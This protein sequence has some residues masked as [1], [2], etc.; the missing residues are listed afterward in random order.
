MQST[1]IER[2]TIDCEQCQGS[3]WIGSPEHTCSACRGFGYTEEVRGIRVYWG[4]RMLGLPLGIPKAIHDLTTLIEAGC[5]IFCA[6]LLLI[7]S[8]NLFD[9]LRAHDSLSFDANLFFDVFFAG[10]A[11]FPLWLGIMLFL[12]L[13]F[14]RF[15][16]KK[17][18]PIDPANPR[19]RAVLVD[20][21]DYRTVK[22]ARSLD[23]SRSA[24]FNTLQVLQASLDLA[25]RSNQEPHPLHLLVSLMG[26]KDIQEIFLR[27][28]ITPK[29]FLEDIYADTKG[30]T[31]GT[32]TPALNHVYKKFLL[33]SFWQAVRL[34][35]KSIEPQHLLFCIISQDSF[36]HVLNKYGVQ[37]EDFYNILLWIK[38]RKLD[39]HNFLGKDSYRRVPHHFMNRS[40]SAV[41]TRV[42]DQFSIDLT[43]YAREGLLLPLVNREKEIDMTVRV[44]Q[45]STKNN[46]LLI[47]EEG[48]GR[49][50]MVRGIA[51]M[52]IRKKVP[53]MLFDK[54]VV[55]LNIGT[56]G[57]GVGSDGGLLKGRVERIMSEVVHA[58]NVIIYIPNIHELAKV[59]SFASTDII[60]FLAPLFSNN[61]I[62]VIGST[63]PEYYHEYIEPRGEFAQTFDIVNVRE[64][65]QDNSMK[66]LSMQVPLLEQQNGVAISYRA[67]EEAIKQSKRFMT[68]R[69]LPQKAI[70]VLAE[71]IVRAK[72]SKGKFLVTDDEVR[73]VF[74]EKTGIPITEIGAVEA[75][76]LLGLEDKIHAQVIGQEQA[77]RDVAAAIR[78]ARVNIGEQERP[79]A[80]FMFM[81]PTGVGKTEL[82]KTLAGVYFKSR[83]RLV[84]ID[85]SEFATPYDMERL[86]GNSNNT[87]EGL[88]TE[89]I[90]RNPFSLL[91]LD[92]FEKAHPVIW[93]LFLQIFDDGR[94]TDGAGKLVNFTNTIIITTSNIGSRLIIEGLQSGQEVEEIKLGLKK[95]LLNIFKPEFLN[96][97][98]DIVIFNALS[99]Q[100]VKKIALLEIKRLNKRLEEEQGVTVEL[101]ETALDRLSAIGYSPEFGA[102]F[103]KRVIREK[104]EDAL[105]V[106]ILK[107]QYPRG[108]TVTIDETMISG[109]GMNKI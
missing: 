51:R 81:G 56:L 100:E 96:R 8:L 17:P 14:H 87:L 107:G 90:K 78:R 27:L 104:I 32:A 35:D 75:N 105:I 85:M 40:W 41:P 25:L 52:V 49:D 2:Q 18:E 10:Y 9:S 62:Q 72:N 23:I 69:L 83:K 109:G 16:Y 99:Q 3:G 39:L 53:G 103:L 47:G 60:S 79:I 15:I 37:V 54:R 4:R 68:D 63:T 33:Q 28:E 46:V 13:Y 24:S 102:R 92:E 19:Y 88:L 26:V 70:D 11:T 21:P 89:P 77:V 20:D 22:S 59:Q 34:E 44:L 7:G 108:S 12:P 76:T 29:N 64:L 43:D 66:V 57:S 65:S 84:R 101:T 98:D 31:P 91:L 73:E 38:Y 58:Q 5:W 55:K 1:I 45:R 6:L 97:F 50:A 80:V 74:S 82:A 61:V 42:L 94:V 48:S 30:I 106:G 71:A 95:E 93:D 67:A 86:I 36:R